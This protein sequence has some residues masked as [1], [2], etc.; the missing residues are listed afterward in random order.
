M[1][2]GGSPSSRA[3]IGGAHGTEQRARRRAHG[4][5]LLAGGGGEHVGV[6]GRARLA[7]LHRL[8]RRD[9]A[10]RAARSSCAT[11]APSTTSCPRR[12]AVPATNTSGAGGSSV[13]A[14]V[15]EQLG[16]RGGEAVDLVGGVAAESATRRREVPGGTVGGRMAV[17][18][19]PRAEQ[20]VGGLE[21]ARLGAAHVRDDRRR[22]ARA[23]PVDVG[24][25]PGPQLVALGRAQRPR[26]AAS[27]AA[28]SA[29][30]RRGGEDV[31]AGAVHE[32]VGVAPRS[33][34]EPAERAERLRQRADA[35]HGDIVGGTVGRVGPEH[36]VGLVEHEQRAVVA[37]TRRAA[38]RPA[39][40]RRP[41]RR[42]SRRRRSR[43][44]RRL[45]AQELVDV[46]GVAGGGRPRA[47]RRR[48]GGRR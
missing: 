13:T 1:V 10:R 21:R 18:R 40:R 16:Q 6:G 45:R 44:A 12:C 31:G 23:Q 28:V 2:N 38:R 34:D 27:A 8:A 7:R 26:S 5:G 11:A 35:Q 17:T 24:A 20:R 48:G 39:R 9:R 4:G 22:V 19:R 25:Q 42:R 36:R 29:G 37:R 14:A 32:Q 30:R 43:A 41:S 15:G 33:G 47:A 46:R 3:A